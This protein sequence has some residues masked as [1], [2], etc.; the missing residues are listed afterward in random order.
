MLVEIAMTSTLTE[1]AA[2]VWNGYGPTETTVW[3][4]FYEVQRNSGRV[5]IGQPIANTALY[6]LGTNFEPVPVGVTGELF[7][8]SR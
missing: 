7:V 1:R 8:Q 5:L 6:V 4:S 2:R 3:S